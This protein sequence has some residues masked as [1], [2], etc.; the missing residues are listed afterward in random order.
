M[1]LLRMVYSCVD[2]KSESASEM[3]DAE[4][5]ESREED[6][7]DDLTDHPPLLTALDE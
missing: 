3:N 4:A 6:G 7:K 2:V 5:D 1:M